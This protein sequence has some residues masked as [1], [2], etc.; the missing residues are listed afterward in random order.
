RLR[1]FNGP[2]LVERCYRAWRAGANIH[3]HYRNELGLEQTAPISAARN[4]ETS[5]G[6]MLLLWVYLDSEK[7]ELEFDPG[8]DDSAEDGR[9]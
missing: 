1:T 3:L 2:A 5:D 7:V 4:V 8:E 9:E 6:H